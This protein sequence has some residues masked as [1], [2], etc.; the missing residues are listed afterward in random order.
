MK[1]I[2]R[3]V[4]ISVLILSSFYGY[5]QL[6]ITGQYKARAEYTNG[7][8][9]PLMSNQDPGF[10]ISQRARLG[11]IYKHEKFQFDFTAQ[12]I[13]TWGETSHLAIDNNGLLSV[14]EANVS[15]FLNKKW[16]LKVGRQP[17]S[18]DNQRIFGALDWAMQGRRH[19]GA[20]LQFKDSTW[21]LDIGATYNQESASNIQ[22]PYGINDYKTF[23]YLWANKSW[24][25]FNASVL[26]LNN[27]MQQFYIEDSVQ[28]NRTNFSQTMGTHLEYKRNK[29]EIMAYGYYQMGFAKNNQTLSA[30]NVSLEGTFKPNKSWGITLGGEILSGTSDE[31]TINDRNESFTPLYGTNHAFNGFMD[32]FYVGNHGNNVGLMDGYLKAKY[33]KGK[34]TFGLANHVFYTAADVKLPTIPFGGTFVAMDPYLGYEVDFT[35]KYQFADEV[36]IQAGYSHLFGTRTMRELK[37]V[38]NDNT[39][40]WA[41]V[42]LTV[43]PFKN[44]KLK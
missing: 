44:F 33:S 22:I 28:K 25:N 7:F 10:F 3:A 5:S 17:I 42:M 40:G 41:Y 21:S 30:Y 26:F 1:H 18:Y 19:D 20:I 27:G 15:L 37:G 39:S 11:V 35:V 32:Y 43:K 9:Q 31:A 6:D 16:T 36:T 23:Q 34:Y 14:Y 24:K 13:R 38:D 29:F 4:L 12:D 2:E 8:Q